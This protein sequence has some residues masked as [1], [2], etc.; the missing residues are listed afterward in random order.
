M[1]PKKLV[2]GIV[3]SA[4]ALVCALAMFAQDNKERNGSWTISPSEESGK[5]HFGLYEHSKDH[6]NNHQS[7]WELKAFEGLDLSV[8]G[9]HDVKFAIRRDAGRFECEGYVQDSEGAG[10]FHFFPDGQF[11]KNMSALGFNVDSDKQFAMAIFD[12]SIQFAK[13]MK[14]RNLRNLD[15][16]KLIAF[17]IFGI[18]A[19][20]IDEIHAEGLSTDDADKLVA[21]RIHGVTP[22]F[23]HSVRAAG[24]RP[25]EDEFVAMRIHGATLEWI[26]ALKKEGYDHV[27]LEKLI[28]FRIHGVSPEFIDKLESLGYKH[29]EPDQLIAMRIHGVTPEF[30][31]TM[32]S[33]GLKDL[34]IDKLVS[35]RIHGIN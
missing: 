33:R 20:F 30:I 31:S 3:A 9:K 23:V 26:A 7:D 24:Y 16:D 22:E 17:R 2:T 4:I 8:K 12:V 10:V 1:S 34:T 29:P 5:V 21:F 6:S 27:E 15:A 13:E 11:P 35:M 19:N 18:S 14:G 28:A 25:T 32:Q